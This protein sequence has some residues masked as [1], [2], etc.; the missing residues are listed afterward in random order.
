[1][2]NQ[3]GGN[4]VYTEMTDT[5]TIEST[6]YFDQKYSHV[7]QTRPPM[8]LFQENMITS[9]GESYC[10]GGGTNTTFDGVGTGGSGGASGG[11]RGS[12]SFLF[13][14]G[15]YSNSNVGN[16]IS[17]MIKKRTSSQQREYDCGR[18]K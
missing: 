4:S 14:E 15:L 3:G 16:E 8:P 7:I 6:L 12:S 13:G 1:M 17:T 11:G 18:T 10:G 2:S 5:Q 9:C